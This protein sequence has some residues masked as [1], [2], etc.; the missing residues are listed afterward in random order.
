MISYFLNLPNIAASWMECFP[1]KKIKKN[2]GSDTSSHLASGVYVP[3][4]RVGLP[5]SEPQLGVSG[6]VAN[7]NLFD[8]GV[9]LNVDRA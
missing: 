1:E 8:A 2:W 3:K 9:L 6:A 7:R 4:F 5:S